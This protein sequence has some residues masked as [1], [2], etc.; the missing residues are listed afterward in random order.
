MTR[1]MVR[2]TREL[3]SATRIEIV[4]SIASAILLTAVIAWI[5]GGSINRL[6]IAGAVVVLLWTG[7][8]LYRFGDR[9]R[10][11]ALDPA[12][13]CAEYYRR[14]L[15]LRRD[16][17]GS[18]WLRHGPLALALLMF[19]GVVAGNGLPAFSRFART[20]PFLAALGVWVAF[21]V[22]RRILQR[23]AIRDEWRELTTP[24]GN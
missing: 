19:A 5:Y 20:L 15:E 22:R 6:Q 1:L 8:T 11:P 18:L 23:R 17:L 3:S 7:V 14:E 10:R 16:H 9:L 13:P 21:G 24:S 2:R 4:S 12:T